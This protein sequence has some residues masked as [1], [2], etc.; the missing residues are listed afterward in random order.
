MKTVVGLSVAGLVVTGI[1]IVL[2]IMAPSPAGPSYATL[3]ETAGF[4]PEQI[5]DLIR[6]GAKLESLDKNGHTPLWIAV[7]FDN[8]A[9]VEQLLGA[10]AT[11]DFS[12]PR[13]DAPLLVVTF[14]GSEP[15]DAV[16]VKQLIEAGADV[17][18]VNPKYGDTPLH[19]AVRAGNVEVVRLLL[20]AGANV[21]AQSSQ[22][23]TPLQSGVVHGH[24]SITGVLLEAG[25]DPEIRNAAGF[26]PIDQLN[27][28]PAPEWIQAVFRAH[29]ADDQARP[30]LLAAAR[31]SQTKMGSSHP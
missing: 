30:E 1:A 7:R 6:A 14:M 2:V 5:P 24:E 28:C 26:R 21:D 17:N 25:A 4:A 16:I 10:G 29:G 19:Y 18:V 31:R 11:P 22:G 20:A 12:G 9:S 27:V 13:K 23:D 8:P 15:V 3:H